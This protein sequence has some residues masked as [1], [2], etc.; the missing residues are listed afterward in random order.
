V[1]WVII[2]V[3]FLVAVIGGLVGFAYF[4]RDFLGENNPFGQPEEAADD[5]SGPKDTRAMNYIEI[6]PIVINF[7]SARG[8]RYIQITV[9]V[10]TRDTESKE[11]LSANT[12]LIQSVALATMSGYDFREMLTPEKK[13]ELL[14]ATK[15][16]TIARF[17]EK[18]LE[19]EIEEF[20]LTGFVVQ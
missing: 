7:E 13:A 10:A 15:E 5:S 12:H 9:T 4:D 14:L 16:A 1:R 3:L 20:L 18:N 19:P 8:F 11:L 2:G 6:K 17:A